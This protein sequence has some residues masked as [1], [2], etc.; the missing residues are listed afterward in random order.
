MHFL[1]E[2]VFRV[3][4]AA[5]LGAALIGGALFAQKKTSAEAMV[6]LPAVVVARGNIRALARA[7]DGDNDGLTD[8]EEAMRG[9]NPQ[10]KTVL[11][12]TTPASEETAEPY[13]PPQTVT[14]Q[15]AQRFFESMVRASG[16]GD[17]APEKREALVGNA[18]DTLAAQ[19]RDALY[20]QADIKSTAESS[21]EA[22]RAYG[23]ALGAIMLSQEVQNENELAIFER[24]VTTNAPKQLEKLAPIAEAYT[25]IIRETRALATP[26]SLARAHVD[27]LNALAMVHTDIV[28]MQNGL[29]DP[30]AALVR[31]KRYH[32]DALGLATALDN[33]RAALEARGIAYTNEETG[34]FLFSLRP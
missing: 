25:A 9:T 15:F 8:W 27:L 23:N 19:T 22:L 30:L 13:E 26:Q 6:E 14:G 1:P 5:L 16:G 32:D 33:T 24:A 31:V 21:V 10:T 12:S 28:A 34:I 18:I 2:S 3:G 7:P 4:G 17:I 11:A 29:N 20:T